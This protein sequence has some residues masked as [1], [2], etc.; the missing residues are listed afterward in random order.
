MFNYISQNLMTGLKIGD[1]EP[2]LTDQNYSLETKIYLG[3]KVIAK[4]TSS[5]KSKSVNDAV[6]NF[7]MLFE[8][9]NSD[10]N[11][12]G[13][14]IKLETLKFKEKFKSFQLQTRWKKKYFFLD[15]INFS[16]FFF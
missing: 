12:S 8:I 1:P 4:G 6:K 16:P 3:P 14:D 7:F 13:N 9:D 10:F 2:D 11:H 5:S 15:K